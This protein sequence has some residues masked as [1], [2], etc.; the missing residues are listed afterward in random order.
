M[1]FLLWFCT[2]FTLQGEAAFPCFSFQHWCH[3][4][5]MKCSICHS[6]S[7]A[8]RLVLL[9]NMYCVSLP[10]PCGV[11]HLWISMA[12]VN[13]VYPGGKGPSPS[14]HS[15]GNL[16]SDSMTTS[17]VAFIYMTNSMGVPLQNNLT[18]FQHAWV[19]PH[20]CGFPWRSSQHLLYMPASVKQKAETWLIINK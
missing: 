4:W 18:L 14:L 6:R 16:S 9:H 7:P 1:L 2:G 12:T 20:F 13:F 8:W 15:C 10:C 3:S 11:F 19:S 5:F 17:W